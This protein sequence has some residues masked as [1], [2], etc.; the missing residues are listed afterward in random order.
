M[1]VRFPVCWNKLGYNLTWIPNFSS[2]K[3]WAKERERQIQSREGESYLHHLGLREAYDRDHRRIRIGPN[4][5][6]HLLQTGAK[7]VDVP[8]KYF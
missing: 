7:I 5:K 1:W 3:G 4:H 2:I 8:T 6:P